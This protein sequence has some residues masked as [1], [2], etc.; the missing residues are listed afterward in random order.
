MSIKCD[1]KCDN[2]VKDNLIDLTS[3][4][5]SNPI[6]IKEKIIPIEKIQNNNNIKD[7]FIGSSNKNIS[8]HVFNKKKK[9]IWVVFFLT[10]MF[11]NHSMGL[12]EM[13]SILII[14]SN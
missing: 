5:S 7:N 10:K 2:I 12:I 6:L 1:V 11:S 14:L 3:K 13:K 9:Q 8:H 4:N